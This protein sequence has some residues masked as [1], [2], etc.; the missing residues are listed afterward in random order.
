M[1]RPSF[2]KTDTLRSVTRRDFLRHGLGAASL[3]GLGGIPFSGCH[4]ASVPV[5]DV[6]IVG[7]GFAGTTLGLHTV[8]NRLNTVIVEAGSY[9]NAPPVENALGPSFTYTNSGEFDYQGP[10]HRQIMVGGTS[11]HWRGVVN[12]LRPSDFR[13]QSQF[14]I[15]A[16]WPIDYDELAPYYCRAE[17]ALW[18]QGYP[19]V[20]GAEPNRD[21]AYP[22][23]IDSSFRSPDVR[24]GGKRL[25]FFSPA[26]SSRDGWPVRIVQHEIKEFTSSRYGTLLH[27]RQ[28][29][30]VVSVDG[31]TIDHVVIQSPGGSSQTIRARTFVLAAGVIET[32][33]LLLLSRSPATASAPGNQSGFVGRH[34]SAHPG[35]PWRFEPRTMAGLYPGVFRS[36][37]WNDVFR[38]EKLNA[39]HLQLFVVGQKPMWQLQPEMESRPDNFVR[40]SIT[41]KDRFGNPL[42]DLVL[43]FSE[44]D[45]KTRERGIEMLR[46]FAR[47]MDIDPPQ[48]KRSPNWRSHPSGTC[49]MAADATSGVVDR[50]SRV[51]GIDN[52]YV[53]GAC[54]FPSSGTSNPTLTVVALAM[55]LGEHL[56]AQSKRA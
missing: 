52:L 51:F 39:A 55:R 22:Q 45:W 4:S 32:P 36:Y 54:V 7:S 31:K 14:G 23:S 18:T 26:R 30:S 53:S 28:V 33:R 20:E 1:T 2:S 15:G 13:M 49:R 6:C 50:N 10:A 48:I 5:Y 34:F 29:T 42:P 46:G 3:W 8:A 44:R 35:F 37:D 43:G 38:R 16:D 25:R 24:L 27:D 11:N 19:P 9:P 21:C 56:V 17:A 40:L 47:S 41:E 12:R